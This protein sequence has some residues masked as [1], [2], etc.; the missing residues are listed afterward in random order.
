MRGRLVRNAGVLIASN[1]TVMVLNFLTWVYLG[2][3]LAPEAF[4]V[5]GFGFALLM[6]FVL[7]VELGFDR[8]AVREA[9]RAPDRIGELVAHVLSIRLVLCAVAG[10]GYAGI[11]LSLD[12]PWPVKATLLLIGLQ[13]VERAVRVEW[14]F[15][16]LE[17]V[18][19]FALRDILL[20]VLTAV[21]VLALVHRPDDV[22]L[23]GAAVAA[24]PLV[25]SLWLLWTYHRQVGPVRLA[26]DRAVWGSLFRPALP[27]AASAV[28][29]EVYLRINQVML[30]FLD[31]TVAVGQYSA[32]VKVLSVVLVVPRAVQIAVFPQFAAALGD[33]ERMRALGRGVTRTMLALGL[34]VAATGPW[35]ASGLVSEVYGADYAAGGPALAVL[36]VSAGV[37]YLNAAV[38]TPLMAWNRERAYLWV[39]GVGAV[40]NVALNFVLIPAVGMVGAAA[41]TVSAEVVV[42]CGFLWVYRE[43]TG[44]LP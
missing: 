26:Y 39:V 41:A 20:A 2:R 42:L 29:I 33:R 10:A 7:A 8:V 3:V 27:L 19:V 24:G 38:G 23:A 40:A 21:G 11:V 37:V 32:T 31:S 13:L 9:A 44:E 5:L 30:E 14:V 17:R 1:G 22:A 36:F 25:A 12:R 18:R 43:E 4:G 35:L 15:Q 34:P 6:Y 28:L 16:A